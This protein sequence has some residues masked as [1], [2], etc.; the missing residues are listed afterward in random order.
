MGIRRDGT[1]KIVGFWT[2]GG[3][4][5]SALVYQEVLNELSQ[6]GPKRIEVIIGEG[7]PGLKEAVL[8]VYPGAR[9]Q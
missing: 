9:F 3:E 1:R 8:R 7:L 5:E 4:G 6:R 2:S